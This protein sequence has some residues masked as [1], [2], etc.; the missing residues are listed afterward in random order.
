MENN[1]RNNKRKFIRNND[2]NNINKLIRIN[3]RNNINKSI[4]NINI[5]ILRKFFY[6]PARSYVRIFKSAWRRFW[7]FRT[8]VRVKNKK[9]QLKS[10]SK[11]SLFN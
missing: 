3:E 10:C 6:Y 8:E 11:I 9:E 2:R 4:R 1:N 7:W 5:L